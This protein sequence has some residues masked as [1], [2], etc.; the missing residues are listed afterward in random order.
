MV[1]SSGLIK[2]YRFEA[3]GPAVYQTL[4]TKS[5]RHNN[6]KVQPSKSPYSLVVESVDKEAKTRK[7]GIYLIR[8]FDKKSVYVQCGIYVWC[9]SDL[10]KCFTV[11]FQMHVIQLMY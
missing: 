10:N 9:Y 1:D 2:S 3:D 8:S 7:G 6:N 5:S 11:I 4:I